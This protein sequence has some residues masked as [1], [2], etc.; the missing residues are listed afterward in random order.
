M[1]RERE[2]LAE[3]EAALRQE[4]DVLENS[5]DRPAKERRMREVRQQLGEPETTADRAPRE[6]A[7]PRKAG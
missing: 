6:R 1:D 3:Y 2:K 5:P 7:T 4:L